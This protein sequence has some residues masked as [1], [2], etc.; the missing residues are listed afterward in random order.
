M[1]TLKVTNIQATGETASRAV[2][3]VA[4]AWINFNGTGTIA[5]RDSVNI[6]SISDDGTGLYGISFT[7][8]FSSSNDYIMNGGINQELSP[9]RGV[10]GLCVIV[11]D[12][13]GGAI[14][15]QAAG[16]IATIHAIGSSAGGNSGA[17]DT[18][19]GY[20][21]FYGDLA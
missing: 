12:I 20:A 13:V 21:S 4:A 9:I 5:V 15:S 10:S 11:A 1:S 3:G 17:Y 8:N 18:Q 14:Q 2:S 7:N 6:S 16:S 19:A